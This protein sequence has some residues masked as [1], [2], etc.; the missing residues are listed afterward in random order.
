[1]PKVPSW[2]R[3]CLWH[4]GLALLLVLILSPKARG[5]SFNT[6]ESTVEAGLACNSGTGDHNEDNEI[7]PS[8]AT[9][10]ASC[11]GTSGSTT[12]NLSA[13]ATANDGVLQAQSSETEVNGLLSMAQGDASSI[14]SLHTNLTGSG[15]LE[16]S[17]AVDGTI[18]CDWFTGCLNSTGSVAILTV[19]GLHPQVFLT[20]STTF[21][22][23]LIAVNFADPIL[24]AE[25]L[26]ANLDVPTGVTNS[27]GSANFTAT[28][29]PLEFFDSNGDLLTDVQ[30]T[31]DTGT[32]YQVAGSAV[33]TPEPGTLFLLAA[34]LLFLG[35]SRSSSQRLRA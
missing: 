5:T 8:T 32:N 7:G 1:M 28:L 31:S 21:S 18:S 9:S 30:V 25:A 22:S 11:S 19:N 26:D 16:L 10:T 29:L 12:V 23:G 35:V 13:S 14:D 4:A 20:G 17:L 6:S 34:G 27:T 24:I 3:P 15:Y 33:P 2:T